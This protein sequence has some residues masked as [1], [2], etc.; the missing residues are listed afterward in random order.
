MSKETEK[1]MITGVCAY[2]GQAQNVEAQNQEEANQKATE[3]CSCDK[4]VSSRY[5][6]EFGKKVNEIITAPERTTG[7][8][9][10]N[11]DYYKLIMVMA[12]QVNTGFIDAVS[13]KLDDRTIKI[14]PRNE[15]G[16]KFKQ[17][18]TVECNVDG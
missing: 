10:L 2:C 3:M 8:S 9:P 17:S 4:S 7:F 12:D 1:K 18:K 15:G 6:I 11:E 14:T 13:F 5:I 16:L